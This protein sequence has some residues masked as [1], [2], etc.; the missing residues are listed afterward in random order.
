[1]RGL[2]CFG[3]LSISFVIGCGPRIVNPPRLST[4]HF[5][6][7]WDMSSDAIKGAAG[8]ADPSVLHVVIDEGLQVTFKKSDPD[9]D[10]LDDVSV[11]RLK[12][13]TVR[14]GFIEPKAA[15]LDSLR[16]AGISEDEIKLLAERPPTISFDESLSPKM[17]RVNR[18]G[19][20]AVEDTNPLARLTD[21]SATQQKLRF[22][23]F[24]KLRTQKKEQLFPLIEGKKYVLVSRTQVSEGANGPEQV[25]KPA[26]EIPDFH[27]GQVFIKSL[28]FSDRTKVTFNEKGED[29][30]RLRLEDERPETPLQLVVL[31]RNEVGRMTQAL[32]GRIELKDEGAELHLRDER[33]GISVLHVYKR[34]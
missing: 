12:L 7:T 29:S 11:G 17:T 32:V 5:V 22:E 14:E 6:G 26:A 16:N 4:T 30:L 27:E 31:A 2:L 33:P 28:Q 21:E 20:V 34:L 15:Y 1:M 23:T 19:K 13:K 3:V 18:V 10:K 25:T 8:A 24:V 9:S